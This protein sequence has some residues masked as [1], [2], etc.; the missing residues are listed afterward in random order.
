MLSRA[1]LAVF[2]AS[3]GAMMSFY[4]LLSVVPQFATSVGAT[5]IGAGLATGALML[6]T[7]LAE[8]ATPA[9]V[10]KFGYRQVIAYGLLLLGLPALALSSFSGLGW[11]LALC[12]VRG[13]GVAILVVLGGAL[14]GSLVPADRRGEGL[15]LYGFV[16]GVPAV[17]GL[18]L[19]LWLAGRAGFP[20]VFIAG[21]LVA[22]VGLVAVPF[23][24]GKKPRAD[25]PVGILALVRRSD[26]LRPSILFL[27]TTMAAGVVVTFLP[28]GMVHSS[29]S[30]VALALLVQAASATIAR[31]WAGA[32]GDRHGSAKLLVPSV[33]VAAVG[34]LAL[35]SLSS[36]TLVMIGMVVF[37]AGFGVAQNASLAV[38]FERV[39]PSA[40]DVV[41]AV[42]NLAYDAG[43]GIGATAFGIVAARTGYAGA[44]GSLAALMVLVILIIVL[45]RSAPTR[46]E[47]PSW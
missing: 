8:L 39:S 44:F 1:V 43:L 27:L 38:M 11:I 40:Y 28:L 16:V 46:G 34:I 45:H 18:P 20:V 10:S 26:L 17:V 36:P 37:G 25:Q 35:V 6:S 42:W 41:S 7:V 47:R 32:H 4:M 15:G 29:G 23:L 21:G 33:L 9:L 2:A 3:F 24:P 13:I 30:F 5:G 22:L 14:V 12:V 31:W 19:G